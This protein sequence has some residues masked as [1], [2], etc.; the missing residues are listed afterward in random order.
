MLSR[1][2]K[3]FIVDSYLKIPYFKTKLFLIIFYTGN[4]KAILH[5][6]QGGGAYLPFPMP[7]LKTKCAFE[8]RLNITKIFTNLVP[9]VMMSHLAR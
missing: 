6:G 2:I 4:L 8:D 1:P 7:T 5:G 3:S 9:E